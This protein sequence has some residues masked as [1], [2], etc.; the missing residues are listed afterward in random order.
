MQTDIIGPGR[1]YSSALDCA[2]QS[3]R[4]EGFGTFFRGIGPTLC[5]AAP[6]NAMVYPRS[7]LLTIDICGI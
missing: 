1:K 3:Y 6:V 2:L 5:R 4:N 7:D